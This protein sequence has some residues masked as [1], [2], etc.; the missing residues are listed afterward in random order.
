MRQRDQHN[1]TFPRPPRSICLC[2]SLPADLPLPHPTAAIIGQKGGLWAVSQGFNLSTQEQTQIISA[3][4]NPGTAQANGIHAG[5]VKFFCLKAD[6]KV[7]YGKQGVS[8]SFLACTGGGTGGHGEVRS[9]LRSWRR[10]ACPCITRLYERLGALLLQ[11]LN[12]LALN[13]CS[14][15]LLNSIAPHP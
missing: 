4:D 5:G 14:L 3:F 9:K 6:D 8:I 2:P 11:Q 13:I 12:V 15:H 7:I 1:H 10:P